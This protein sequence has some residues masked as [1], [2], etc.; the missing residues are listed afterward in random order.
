[1]TFEL[2]NL[3][4][5]TITIHGADYPARMP[6]KAVKALCEMWD[7]EYFDLLNRLSNDTLQYNEL[8][9]ILFI[10]LK[11]GGVEVARE[12]LDDIEHDPYFITYLT[13]KIIELFD[14]TQKAET[15]LDI[16]ELSKEDK[17]KTQSERPAKK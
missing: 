12:A 16:S 14:R 8:F 7:M 9:D 10:T 4:P 6:F 13:N 2:K 11:A 17:K 5:V 15:I 3:E 1:M